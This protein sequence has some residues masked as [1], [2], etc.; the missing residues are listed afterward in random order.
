MKLIVYYTNSHKRLLEEY[1]IP[2]IK[3][4]DNLE[5]ILQEGKQISEDGGYFSKGFNET[6][7]NK[8]EFLLHNLKN[9]ENNEYVLFSDV[10]IIFLKGINQY[11]KDYMNYDAVFQKGYYGLNT[12]FFIMRKTENTIVLL[13]S[14]IKNCHLYPNDQDTL[15]KMIQGSNV[16]YTTFDD[17][18]LSPAAIIGQKIW[19]GETFH[20]PEETLVF[21]ACWCSG[22]NNKIN[23]LNYVKNYRES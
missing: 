7:K 1:F 21:H 2:S 10:D 11:L 14:V 8:I 4:N 18:I 22:V 6:T 16:K 23:L 9:V 12:G 3:Q 20:I 19:V 5:L 13:E 15:N 17:K